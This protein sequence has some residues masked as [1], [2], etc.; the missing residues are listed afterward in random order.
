MRNR[1][2]ESKLKRD[3]ISREIAYVLE[4]AQK[5]N[6]NYIDALEKY[7]KNIYMKT[8]DQFNKYLANKEI[9]LLLITEPGIDN[10]KQEQT[11]VRLI[12][13][14]SGKTMQID[15]EDV[16]TGYQR[17]L[18]SNLNNKKQKKKRKRDSQNYINLTLSDEEA[19]PNEL[20]VNHD[21]ISTEPTLIVPQLN[22]TTNNNTVDFVAT[23]T[24]YIP[25]TDEIEFNP[26]FQSLE[27]T[28]LPEWARDIDSIN[29]SNN[30]DSL[31]KKRKTEHHAAQSTTIGSNTVNNIDLYNSSNE[32]SAP[33]SNPTTDY[34]ENFGNE[35]R[36]A[37]NSNFSLSPNHGCS[38]TTLEDDNFFKSLYTETNE[39]MFTLPQTNN[40]AATLDPTFDPFVKAE[41]DNTRKNNNTSNEQ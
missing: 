24:N 33:W 9:H 10:K 32:Y 1:T 19:P 3:R 22:S 16:M 23:D 11:N 39:G 29:N 13:L 26:F 12:D 7:I 27:R 17:N 8:L 15:G 34:L 41:A 36:E 30:N 40:H 4:R 35:M 18:T 31:A 6:Q 5:N 37:T 38:N 2:K 28:E 14:D 20:Q 25:I 21:R